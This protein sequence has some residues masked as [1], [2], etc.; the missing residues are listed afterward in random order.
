MTVGRLNLTLSI[1]NLIIHF[2]LLQLEMDHPTDDYTQYEGP[3]PESVEKEFLE[4]R[5]SWNF[6]FLS[7]K[8]KTMKLDPFNTSCIG[9]VSPE[10]YTIY[11]R[12]I[13]KL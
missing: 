10:N 3:D 4:N 13:R 9:I 8:Q 11:L 5:F 6:N 12:V 7:S 1:K 2:I